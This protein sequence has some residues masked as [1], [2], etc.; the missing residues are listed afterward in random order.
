MKVLSFLKFMTVL[1]C[2]CL[3]FCA[4]K[5]G[6]SSK[7]SV[8]NSQ[9][10]S[11][12][13]P[14]DDEVEDDGDIVEEPKD[15]TPVVHSIELK[16]EGCTLSVGDEK[17]A[18]VDGESV[19]VFVSF[20]CVV[21]DENTLIVT[22]NGVPVCV[23]KEE[24]G[25][26]TYTLT[27]VTEDTEVRAVI[28]KFV[29][30]ITFCAPINFPFRSVVKSY[31]HGEVIQDK[32]LPAYF[33]KDWICFWDISSRTVTASAIYNPLVCKT[34]AT[35]EEFLAME[36]EGNYALVKDIDFDGVSLIAKENGAVIPRFTGAFRG[37]G[38]TLKNLTFTGADVKC[39]FGELRGG[40]VQDLFV[41]NLVFAGTESIA[42]GSKAYGCALIGKM[43]MG[44]KIKDS[45][46]Q[47]EYRATGDE[48]HC[49]AGLVYDLQE[50]SF[51][52]CALA[53]R[54]PLGSAEADFVFAV[55][56]FSAVDNVEKGV[57]VTYF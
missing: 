14:A 30:E 42:L 5:D 33:E 56:V 44:A 10:E 43:R 41:E 39:L 37:N 25:V 31:E 8:S 24:N 27:D 52:N 7:N 21:Y 16:G 2:S 45:N 15:E 26:Y 9:Q 49:N 29:Y 4:C 40:I 3:C 13:T 17:N 28:R 12:Q 35:V 48:N 32:D 55:C 54:T 51:E 20:D 47:I 19:E 18:V 57:T 38:Y 53:L 46:F 1:L 23:T 36:S 34:V 50:G 11:V 6:V 22:A